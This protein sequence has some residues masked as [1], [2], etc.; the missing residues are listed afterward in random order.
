GFST[1]IL[2][3]IRDLRYTR[4]PLQAAVVNTTG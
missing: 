3:Q 1:Q 4:R 2:R